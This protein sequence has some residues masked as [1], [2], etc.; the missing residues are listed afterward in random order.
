MTVLP[1]LDM[2][3]ITVWLRN[4]PNNKNTD[5]DHLEFILRSVLFMSLR[6]KSIFAT[7]RVGNTDILQVLEESEVEDFE[8]AT[9]WVWRVRS[10]V[11]GEPQI[12]LWLSPFYNDRSWSEFEMAT[13]CLFAICRISQPQTYC[14]TNIL[15]IFQTMDM[16]TYQYQG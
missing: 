7:I 10:L 13:D 4:S 2:S 15:R 6:L 1:T 12:R 5:S 3:F 11:Q 9:L 8:A 16:I 14:V